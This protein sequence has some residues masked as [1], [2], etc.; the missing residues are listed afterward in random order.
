MHAFYPLFCGLRLITI[1]GVAFVAMFFQ[2]TTM[3]GALITGLFGRFFGGRGSA[4]VA[5]S[6][7]AVAALIS[8]LCFYEVA[9]CGCPCH[10]TLSGWFMASLFQASW[11]FLFDRHFEPPK[12]RVL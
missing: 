6:L 4:V 11:G 7:Q 10:L 1:D 2:G 9:L 5:S 3:C 12:T 8:A